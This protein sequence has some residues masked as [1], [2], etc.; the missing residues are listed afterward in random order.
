MIGPSAVKPV[1]PIAE[2]LTTSQD[3]TIGQFVYVIR[4]RIQ[5]APEKAIFVF[6]DEI[7]PPAAALMSA[8]YEEYK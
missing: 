8:I 4:K 6:V 2:A 3:L 1:D 5:L 7:L